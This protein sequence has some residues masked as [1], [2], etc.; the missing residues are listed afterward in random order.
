MILLLGPY[1]PEHSSH[2]FN[3]LLKVRLVNDDC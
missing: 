3:D 2:Y 1:N